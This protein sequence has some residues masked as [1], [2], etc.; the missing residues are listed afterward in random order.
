[1][2]NLN[3]TLMSFVRVYNNNVYVL[4]MV[5]GLQMNIAEFM[6]K[7]GELNN[8]NIGE[9]LRFQD[10]LVQKLSLVKAVIYAEYLMFD[11]MR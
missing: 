3:K 11:K 5:L 1:M 4:L 2:K 8:K 9:G 10:G 7:R 6:K